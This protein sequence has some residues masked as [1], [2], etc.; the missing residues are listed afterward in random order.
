MIYKLKSKTGE[1]IVPPTNSITYKGLVLVGRDSINWNEP[2]QENFAKIADELEDKMSKVIIADLV[3]DTA[4]IIKIG[5]IDKPF[6]DL[7]S[8]NLNGRNINKLF[9]DI[10]N[11]G[12]ESDFD[13]TFFSGL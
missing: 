6:Q 5:S 11:I 1:I 8:T 3:P 2:I 9:V 7:F 12:A 13:S 10:D 4:D